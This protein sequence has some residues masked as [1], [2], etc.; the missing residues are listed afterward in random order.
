[1]KFYL[2][3]ELKGRIDTNFVEQK[4]KKF[5]V[6]QLFFNNDY[7]YMHIITDDT[8]INK[9]FTIK[10]FNFLG[11]DKHFREP[12]KFTL[13]SIKKYE[14]SCEAVIFIEESKFWEYLHEKDINQ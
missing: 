4:E 12:V 2:S 5:K 10:S 8:T 11:S 6:T 14:N 3:E 1:M 13:K 9:H 7:A